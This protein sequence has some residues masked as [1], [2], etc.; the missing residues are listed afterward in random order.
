M[1]QQWIN[2]AI[3][4]QNDIHT[5]TYYKACALTRQ[6]L[7]DVCACSQNMVT[8]IWVYHLLDFW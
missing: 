4:V 6:Q 5:L 8:Y 2:K 3:T 7:Q 1:A